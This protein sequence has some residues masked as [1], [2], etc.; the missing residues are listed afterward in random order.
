MILKELT[1]YRSFD[2]DFGAS[3]LYNEIYTHDCVEFTL[4]S[5]EPREIARAILLLVSC[6]MSMQALEAANAAGITNQNINGNYTTNIQGV[7]DRFAF[8]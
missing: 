1:D 3:I 6:H 7:E 4:N 5:H 8:W 2:P